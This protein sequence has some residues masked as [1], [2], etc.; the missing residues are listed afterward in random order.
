MALDLQAISEYYLWDEK[1][2]DECRAW[3]DL[4]IMA[5]RTN[6]EFLVHGTLYSLP[7]G[8]LAT[9]YQI[10]QDR[11][12]WSQKAIRKFIS[13]QTDRQQMGKQISPRSS[14]FTILNIEQYSKSGKQK[15]KQTEKKGQTEG[16]TETKEKRTSG[17]PDIEQVVAYAATIAVIRSDAEYCFY[18][19]EGNGWRNGSHTVADWKATIRAWKKANY[20]PSQRSKQQPL[21][22]AQRATMNTLQAIKDFAKG[23]TN[24]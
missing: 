24:D 5:T 19:W 7:I 3:M 2:F 1:P 22:F 15:G 4:L 21:T 16:Q 9:S 10:L 12:G 23:E 20:L 11:W 17:R 13:G 18:H 8:Q 14:I 6:R